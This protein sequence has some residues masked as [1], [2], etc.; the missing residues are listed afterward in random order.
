M[1]G[2]YSVDRWTTIAARGG[3]GEGKTDPVFEDKTRLIAKPDSTPKE[4]HRGRT[5]ESGDEE[6]GGP[7]LEFKRA[8]ICSITPSRNTTI[9][10]AIVMASI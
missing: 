9:L 5:D 7:V 3:R 10:L 1:F 8:L 4:V 2:S 6:I